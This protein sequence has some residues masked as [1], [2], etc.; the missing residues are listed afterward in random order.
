[1]NSCRILLHGPKESIRSSDWTARY[2]GEEFVI[3]LPETTLRRCHCVAEKVRVQCASKNRALTVAARF[4]VAGLDAS[5]FGAPQAAEALLLRADGALFESQ[6]AGRNKV[7]MG[8]RPDEMACL[9][10]GCP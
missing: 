5:D 1:M 2:G 7:M 8:T 10:R 6:Q 4:G 3:V 9:A